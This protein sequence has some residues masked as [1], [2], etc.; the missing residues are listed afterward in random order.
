MSGRVISIAQATTS[1]ASQVQR[2]VVSVKVYVD[3]KGYVQNAGFVLKPIAALEKGTMDGPKAVVLHR[4]DSGGIA[5]PLKSFESGIGTHFIVDKDGTVYQ[6]ASLLKKTAH[7]G[8]IKSRCFD[9]GSCPVDEMKKIKS[10]GWAPAKVYAHEKSK[11]YPAR[12]P[13]NEDS[14]GIETVA[15]HD[16]KSWE[17]PT[18]AQARAIQSIIQIIKREYGL[19][20]ADIYEHDRI[21]YKTPGEGAG[22]FDATA[23]HP[24]SGM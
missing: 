21:S 13:M 19:D 18:P 10:W 24:P 14:V 23:V 9:S 6:A 2:K 20:N 17:A 3:E 22:L 7:V 1:P 5:S 15:D 16:G 4:T 12:Y 11:D 8:K